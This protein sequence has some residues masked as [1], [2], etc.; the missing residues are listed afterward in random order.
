MQ[1]TTDWC[2]A[3]I[4]GQMMRMPLLP[5]DPEHDQRGLKR[6]WPWKAAGQPRAEHFHH[7]HSLCGRLTFVSFVLIKRGEVYELFI[8]KKKKTRKLRPGRCCG[9]HS[10]CQH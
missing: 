9:A 10:Q 3:H 7:D 1:T 2:E 5:P 8:K 6:I 4:E